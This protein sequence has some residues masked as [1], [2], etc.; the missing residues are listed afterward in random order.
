MPHAPAGTLLR[1]TRASSLG[2]RDYTYRGDPYVNE[3][4]FV[5]RARVVGVEAEPMRVI[6]KTKRRQRHVKRATSKG[7][8]TVLRVTEVRVCADGDAGEDRGAVVEE[9]GL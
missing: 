4:Y 1:L 9:D 5:C 8:F 7:R 2:S 3:R 6:E